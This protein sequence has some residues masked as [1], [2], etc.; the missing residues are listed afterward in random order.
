M[1]FA[2][3]VVNGNPYLYKLEAMRKNN[4]PTNSGIYIGSLKKIESTIKKW[5]KKGVINV[6]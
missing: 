6:S 4:I 2:I 3:K 5:K 1:F